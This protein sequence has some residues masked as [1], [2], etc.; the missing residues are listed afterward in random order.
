MFA[1]NKK[2][3]TPMHCAARAGRSK[4]VSFLTELARSRNRLHELLRK[5][6]GL[7]ET[8][9]HDA[10]RIGNSSIVKSLLKAD[11]KLA[12]YPEEGTSPLYLA[13]SLENID[14]TRI[15]H[16]MSNGNLSFCGPN[17]QNALHAATFGGTVIRD[18]LK[19]NSSLTTRGDRDGSTPLHFAS[20]FGQY[21]H[22]FH[23]L[24]QAN[25]TLVYQADS[26]GLFPIH[27]AASMGAL[28]VKHG[29]FRIFCSL[30]G[31]K[32]V[33]VSLAN[34]SMQTPIDLARNLLPRGLYY[35]SN[36]VKWIYKA[37]TYI[38]ATYSRRRADKFERLDP[39]SIELKPEDESK[40]EETVKDASQIL[41][42]GSVLITTVAFGATFAL[43]GG[44]I[45]D[46]HKN[47]GTATRAGRYTFDAFMMANTLAFICSSMATI[48]LMFSG[49]SM[50]KLKSRQINL[51]VSVYLIT[52]S[53]TSLA[54]AF[55]LGV[56]MVV[57]PVALATAT[58]DGT[59]SGIMDISRHDL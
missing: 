8:A 14:I 59:N 51:R 20:S 50:V 37:L 22:G 19:W 21:P 13:V 39:N 34:N 56:Y 44:Y 32:N 12:I 30:Y 25:P 7:K 2:G 35:K 48:G 23:Q 36:N 3:D 4:M 27:V 47:G 46:D 54:A 28:A 10:V 29:K 49:T 52:R 24:F 53:V 1:P 58:M 18:V 42:L 16:D 6:N 57:A 55:A 11:P 15:L 41:G 38:G 33:H 17:G 5:E 9:L 31:N 43:P 45:E 40:E 26:K